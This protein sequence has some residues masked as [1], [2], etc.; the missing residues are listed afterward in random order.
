[1]EFYEVKT[2]CMRSKGVMC[3]AFSGDRSE[4]AEYCV[5]N[6]TGYNWIA[7]ASKHVEFEKGFFSVGEP[8]T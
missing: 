5:A 7:D 6:D 1:M 3:E 4:K 8:I 2:F